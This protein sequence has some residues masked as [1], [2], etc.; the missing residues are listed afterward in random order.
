MSRDRRRR[1]VAS[2][3]WVRRAS[4]RASALVNRVS[5]FGIAIVFVVVIA[6]VPA[7]QQRHV[8]FLSL[9]MSSLSQLLAIDALA[10]WQWKDYLRTVD[11]AAATAAAAPAAVGETATCQ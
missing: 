4:V 2:M 1:V 5:P 11:A 10:E 9:S 7:S 8:S 6:L 3:G